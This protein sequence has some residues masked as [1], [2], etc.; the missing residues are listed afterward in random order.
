MTLSGLRAWKSSRLAAVR[1][2]HV[3]EGEEEIGSKLSCR[4]LRRTARPESRFCTV[5]DTSMW[6]QNT[7]A[8]TT[9]LR[10]LVL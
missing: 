4:S 8:I 9:S 10:G 3:N 1:Y 7:P 6:D 2:H 5:C